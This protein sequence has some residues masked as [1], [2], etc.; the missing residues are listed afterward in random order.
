MHAMQTL[1]TPILGKRAVY[2]VATTEESRRGLSCR[3]DIGTLI[4]AGWKDDS[5]P[6]PSG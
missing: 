3:A 1:L 2:H 5:F 4:G 6:A